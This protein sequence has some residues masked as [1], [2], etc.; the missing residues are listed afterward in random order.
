MTHVRR[1]TIVFLLLLGFMAVFSIGLIFFSRSTFLPLS[2]L[3]LM[4][5][6]SMS[7]SF[8]ALTNTLLLELSPDDMRG[9]VMSLMSID[10]GLVPVGAILAGALASW[11]GPEDG[12][13]IMA[14]ACLI[15]T[16]VAAIIAPPLRRL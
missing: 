13:L 4:A 10:R 7:T 11:R 14:G 16:V 5:A 12:L 1:W 9:R 6:A 15:L 8:M 3:L 2:I